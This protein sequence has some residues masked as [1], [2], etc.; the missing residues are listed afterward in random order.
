MNQRVTF[1]NQKIKV[2]GN[3]FTPPNYDKTKKYPVVIVGHPATT[4]SHIFYDDIIDFP[5]YFLSWLQVIL[6]TA[7]S[8]FSHYLRYSLRRAF[9]GFREAVFIDS[10]LT[11]SSAIASALV[12][13]IRNIETPTEVL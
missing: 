12:P 8:K 1:P 11:V 2:A 6:R 4:D 13:A 5:E 9:T 7:T 3:F 10:K